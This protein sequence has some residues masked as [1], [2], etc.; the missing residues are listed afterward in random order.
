MEIPS[1][2]FNFATFEIRV[3]FPLLNFL[4]LVL[5]FTLFTTKTTS[6]KHEFSEIPYS[7]YCKG[8]VEEQQSTETQLSPGN[9]LQLDKAV[10]SL[11]FENPQFNFNPISS[12]IASFST[13]KA[14]ETKS[15]V[16]VKV[17][18]VLNLIGPNIISYFSGDVTRRGLRLVKVRPPRFEPRSNV[19]AEFQLFGFWNSHSGKL[20][21]VGSGS[22]SS[23]RSVNV[24][25]KFNYPNSSVLDTS[26]INGTLQCTMP[27][28]TATYFKPILILGVSRMRYNFT[29]IIQEIENGGFSVY[30]GMEN[31]SLSLPN[32]QTPNGI[33]SIITWGLRFELDYDN[34]KCNNV[35]CSFGTVGDENFPR[36]MSIKVVDCLEDGKVRYLLQFSNST[37]GKGLSFYPLTTLVA[38]GEWDEKKKRVA[39][40]A[41]QMFDKR[42]LRG[43]LIRLAFSFP[44]SLSLK[45]RST[46]VGK[47]WSTKTKNLG[48]VSFYSPANVN[49]RIKASY[50]YSEHEK[51]QELCR[52]YLDSKGKTRTY[53]D[54]KSP[55]LRFDM[56][57]RN[58][59]GQMAY[60]Y[61]S[62]LYIR[63]RF[64]TPF[65]NQWNHSST[66]GYVNISYVISFKTR[67]EFD[68]GGKIPGLKMV[69][70]SAEGVYNTK[71]G[72]M[73]M[74]GC[75]HMPYE[76]FQKKRLLDC[77]L[78][79]NIN[80]S[81]LNSK[82]EGMVHG[83][84]KSTRKKPDP[85]Y[86]E[87][88][89]FGSSS[90]TTIQARES[91][92]R[93]DLE[94]TMVLISNT[95]ACIFIG[96]QLFHVKKNPGMLPFISV[97]M[98]VVLTLAHMIPLLLN[99]EALFMV[100]RKQNVFLGTDQW[101]EINEVLVRVITMIAFLLQFRLLQLAWSSRNSQEVQKT[102]WTP[103]KKVLYMCCPLYI[104]IGLT[105]WLAYSLQN[106][107]MKTR[108]KLASKNVT[109][110][111]ALQSYSGL[112]LDTFLVPQ[113][114][115]NLFCD[116]HGTVLASSFYIGSTMVRLLPHVY[117]LY[118]RHSSSWFYDK[119]YADPG[120]D[121]YSTAWDIVICCTGMLCVLVIYMQ[122]RFGGQS[123]L[124]KRF[125][126]G[127]LYQKIPVI[128]H[129]QQIF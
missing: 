102:I 67:D 29:Y 118:R 8:V 40:V 98:L 5:I 115:F 109:F 16:I 129:E 34:Y 113:I 52:K 35:S 124:P 48:S 53:P 63:D 68:F 86:F 99:F 70:I 49:S 37:Y 81:P 15:K 3:S 100:N 116:T 77:E 96:L 18:A 79:I 107:H 80:F 65:A 64:Y 7:K 20:C 95:L 126:E 32:A 60:G 71:N 125:R 91:I 27:E 47:M 110:W 85:L 50:E 117:D 59:K 46:I 45:R 1:A 103:D 56:M 30:D 4:Q 26:L 119:I 101:L 97:V 88:I 51:V 121:Y 25:F 111:G 87:P 76:K 10:Y 74:I 72:V 78:A 41:C 13:R 75:K 66:N 58:K 54:E 105:A 23:L 28:G 55:N 14:Y 84:I 57:V 127:V 122:Q 108:F 89:D 24:A 83:Y 104:A 21:M 92:W 19:G 9:Y 33:C 2:S 38:E 90:I 22:V 61:A 112:V 12:Q 93:M 36:F 106:S 94:I 73:C 6:I 42:A 11:G 69:E 120:M 17:Y 62:P 128:I 123:V 82:D 43:C 39:L 31:V 114:M 44:S